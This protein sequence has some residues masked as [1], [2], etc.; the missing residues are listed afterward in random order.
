MKIKEIRS[1]KTA[2]LV[3]ELQKSRDKLRTLRFDLVTKKLKKHQEIPQTKR[4]IAR[5]LTVLSERELEEMK[6][7][8]YG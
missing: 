2:E 6:E 1:K 8:N 5:I 4:K 3:K 7:D